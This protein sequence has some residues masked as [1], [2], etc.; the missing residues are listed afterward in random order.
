M[1]LDRVRI[2]NFRSIK[3][4]T[5]KLDPKCRVLVGINE[6]GKSNIL[7][8]LSLLDKGTVPSSGDIRQ[9]L[10][11]ETPIDEATIRFYFSLAKDERDLI[12]DSVEKTVACL[13][14]SSKII[15]HGTEEYSLDEF[16][17]T[18]NEG[19]YW[20][21]IKENKKQA[22]YF[23][24]SADWEITGE[25][26]K[27][28]GGIAP[29]FQ[30]KINGTT[31]P[32]SQFKI[33]NTKEF[34]DIPAKYLESLTP[35]HV[36]DVVGEHIALLIANSLPEVVFWKYSEK[37]LLPATIPVG[38][39][40]GNVNSCIPL[41]NMF[42]LAGCEDIQKEINA[43]ITGPI[44]AFRNLLLKVATHTTKHFKKVWKDYAKVKF[45]LEENGSNIRIGIEEENYWSM[46]Q[47]SDGFK[48]FISF[49]L[50]I[51][52]N[53]K[54]GH[55]KNTLLLVDEPDV[56]LHISG[57]RYLRD[58]LIKISKENYVVY[59]THSIFMMDTENIGRHVIVSKRNEITD[60]KDADTS[61]VV[62][63]EVLNNAVGFT[64]YDVLQK[65]N[66]LF[67]GWRDKELFQCAVSALPV[68]DAVRKYFEEFG[69]T[70]AKGVKDVRNVS[71]FLGLAKRSCVIISDADAPAKESQRAHV[72]DRRYGLWLRYDEVIKGGGVITGEDFLKD[73]F[74]QPFLVDL[75]EKYSLSAL[76][77][78][79]NGL[80]NGIAERLSKDKIN[81]DRHPEIL[82]EFKDT[83][84][85]GVTSAS[86][87][88][89]Y[90]EFLKELM[91]TLQSKGK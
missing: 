54:L 89:S 6:S 16:V 2:K 31:Q 5:L 10:P 79:K 86:I 50:Q 43:A 3:E 24:L 45:L 51:S 74:V 71:S 85:T 80:I 77:G 41:K 30:L 28:I 88:E 87:H 34:S 33:V 39:F 25:W 53:A 44:N 12:F 59:A 67:E 73:E 42:K 82:R 83:I 1:K 38:A 37:N 15:K 14:N 29:E 7:R 4:L 55:L 57:A 75:K 56:N 8:A 22:R 91:R 27:I 11:D 62:D 20:V 49:L 9:S 13:D 63:E 60:T 46:E 68:D 52:V 32:L 90:Y 40:T 69:F 64:I 47:R 58:E 76:P 19:V 26:K 78:K 66:I 65:H 17:A 23:V 61:N 72:A 70:F 36:N 84:F 81:A 35:E 48:R 18:K 21:D